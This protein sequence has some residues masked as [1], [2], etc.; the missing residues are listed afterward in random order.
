ML[1]PQNGLRSTYFSVTFLLVYRQLPCA[2]NFVIVN[3][4]QQY[5]KGLLRGEDVAGEVYRKATRSSRNNDKR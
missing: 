1:Q 5:A 2:L 4:A 3:S